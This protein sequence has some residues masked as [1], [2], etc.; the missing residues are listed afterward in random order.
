MN[1]ILKMSDLPKNCWISGIPNLE[2][3]LYG[4]PLIDSGGIFIY[5]YLYVYFTYYIMT[6]DCTSLLV[7]RETNALSESVCHYFLHLYNNQSF[8]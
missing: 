1:R 2:T 6:F 8:V 3:D 4:Q 5:V 7:N